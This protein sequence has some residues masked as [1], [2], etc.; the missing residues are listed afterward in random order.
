MR[1]SRS[2]PGPPRDAKTSLACRCDGAELL[3]R[4]I[5]RDNDKGIH[6]KRA[7]QVTVVDLV[8]TIG[9]YLTTSYSLRLSNSQCRTHAWADIT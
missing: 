9:N 7:I 6:V 5:L 3:L 8:T 4:D 2:E 1:G